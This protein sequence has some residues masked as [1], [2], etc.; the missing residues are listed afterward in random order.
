MSDQAEEQGTHTGTFIEIIAVNN[1]FAVYD[2]SLRQHNIP[3]DRKAV[4]LVVFPNKAELFKWLAK[5]WTA[6]PFVAYG[7]PLSGKPA[8]PIT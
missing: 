7:S 3:E 8:T 2:F 1:G 4:P 5:K 6:V